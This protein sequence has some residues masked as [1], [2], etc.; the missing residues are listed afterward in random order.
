[1]ERQRSFCKPHILRLLYD[2]NKT[3]INEKRNTCNCL[4]RLPVYL[5]LFSQITVKPRMCVASPRFF[6]INYFVMA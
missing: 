4:Q 1:M 6:K 3:G 5:G 2:F